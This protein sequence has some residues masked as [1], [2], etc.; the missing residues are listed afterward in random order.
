MGAREGPGFLLPAGPWI[1]TAVDSIE[2]DN[3]PIKAHLTH[4]GKTETKQD[5][6]SNQMIK[7]IP[8]IIEWVSS[9]FTLLPGD[10]ICTGSPAGTAEMVPGDR[11]EVEIPGLGKLANPVQA[12]GK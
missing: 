1:E 2:I 11:I 12:Y 5:S 8:E 9:A 3:Q 7:D 10:V 4:D 6:N